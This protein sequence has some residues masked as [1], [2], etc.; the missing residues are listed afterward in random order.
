MEISWDGILGKAIPEIKM[1]TCYRVHIVNIV[2]FSDGSKYM[3]DVG[4]G[5]DGATAPLPLLEGHVTHNIG[6]QEIQL[7]HG[8]IDQQ[9]DK[10][11]KLWIYQY[12][13]GADKPWNSFYCFPEFEFL[14]ADFEVMNC[15][16]ST[17]PDCFQTSTMLVI[18]F[19]RKADEIYGKIMLV[20]GEVKENT[21]GKTRVIKVCKTDEERVESLKEYFGITITNEQREGIRGWRTAL[22]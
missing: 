9:V 22:K 20:N 4:F 16:T 19:L 6:S 12:R 2:T 13:N 11:R 15:F 1:I 5:G 10:S 17:S 3:V 21:G 18:K 8:T 7:V 14:H